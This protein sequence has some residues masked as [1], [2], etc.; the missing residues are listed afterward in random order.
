MIIALILSLTLTCISGV[1]LYNS[2]GKSL[3]VFVGQPLLEVLDAHEQDLVENIVGNED[4][5]FCEETHEL[6]SNLTLFLI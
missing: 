2:K 1:M 4:E 3:F 6:L 5:E